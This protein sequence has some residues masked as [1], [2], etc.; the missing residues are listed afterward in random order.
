M[1]EACSSCSVTGP[2]MEETP[3]RQLGRKR[4]RYE[5]EWQKA[6]QKMKRNSGQEYV[7][8]K[9]KSVSTTKSIL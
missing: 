2:S 3:H 4:V 9:K 7:T 8:K 5:E 1:A 6:A